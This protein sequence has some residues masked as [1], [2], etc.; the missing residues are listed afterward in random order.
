MFALEPAD[1]NA[2]VELRKAGPSARPVVLRA[3]A[4]LPSADEALCGVP[5]IVPKPTTRW[6]GWLDDEW[7]PI[8]RCPVGAAAVT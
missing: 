3:H 8:D 5:V 2:V 6:S 7:G 1:W 4:A